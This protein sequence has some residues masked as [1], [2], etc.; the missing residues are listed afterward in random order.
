VSIKYLLATLPKMVH[1]ASGGHDT[2]VENKTTALRF[3]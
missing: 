2:Q 1:N 3:S